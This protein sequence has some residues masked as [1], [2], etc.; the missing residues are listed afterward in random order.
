[1]SASSIIDFSLL[2]AFEQTAV[3]LTLLT[4]DGYFVTANPALCRFTGRSLA[5]LQT[6]NLL[7]IVLPADKEICADDLRSLATG[8]K[9]TVSEVRYLRLD[10]STV[11]VRKSLSIL[12][13]SGASEPYLIGV[14]EDVTDRKLTEATLERVQ[15]ELQHTIDFNPQIPWTADAQG[16]VLGMSSRY[17]EKTGLS[18]KTA[19][20][21][22]WI[23]VCATEDRERMQTAWKHSIETG[24]PYDIEHRIV[25]SSGD[26]CWMRTRAF[27]RRDQAGNI[28]RWYGT[29]EDINERKLAQN[30]VL[31][32]EKLAAIGKLAGTIAH[33]INNPLEAVTNLVHL[34]RTSTENDEIVLYLD[35][36]DLELR[37]VAAITSKTLRFHRQT[38]RKETAT[39]P[40]LI[41]GAL[42]IFDQKLRQLG[43]A[44]EFRE[45][46]QQGI[47][48]L[49]GEIRQ[50]LNNLVANA[51]DAL[52]KE[53]GRLLL[54]CRHGRDWKNDREGM[55]IT[56]ADNG[57]GMSPEVQQR[58]FEAFFSTKGILGT[59]IGLWLS[60][61]IM[62]RHDGKLQCRSWQ[63][64]HRH[65]T[66]FSLFLPY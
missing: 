45:R 19:F 5:E 11:W 56:V 26:E 10:G 29:T 54:R 65:G 15:V 39:F 37:R 40:Q 46:T 4:L 17:S 20:G 53:R 58:A 8:T 60:A 55:V 57:G 25:T 27:P 24:E 13:R 7:A 6:L 22:G 31:I 59:G 41:D 28:V 33:E 21:D 3:G 38:T 63:G 36:A 43:A 66:V 30:A 14:C 34:A 16:K 44:V 42:L 23:R 1:M 18:Y 9:A 50:V 61:E 64:L 62:K 12:E 49:L 2:P 48:C 52:P 51:I 32:S 35:Q 47:F